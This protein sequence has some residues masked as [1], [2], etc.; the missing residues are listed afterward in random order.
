MGVLWSVTIS[1]GVFLA[2][3]LW[4]EISGFFLWPWKLLRTIIRWFVENYISFFKEP[5]KFLFEQRRSIFPWFNFFLLSIGLL[6]GVLWLGR[7]PEKIDL[8][9]KYL[10]EDSGFWTLAAAIAA[11]PFAWFIWFI[12]DRLK[13]IDQTQAEKDLV[14]EQYKTS[15]EQFYRLIDWATDKTNHPRAASSILRFNE[16]L[17]GGEMVPQGFQITRNDPEE[18]VIEKASHNPFQ[19]PIYN[20]L[21]VIVGERSRPKEDWDGFDAVDGDIPK[22]IKMGIETV[23]RTRGWLVGRDFSGWALW[24]MDLNGVNLEF[25]N[26][27]WTNLKKAKLWDANLKNTN[28][29]WTDLRGANLWWADLK[30]ANLRGAKL[31][32]ALIWEAHLQG[33]NLELSHLDNTTLFNSDLTKTNLSGANNLTWEQV[34]TTRN[35]QKAKLPD[36][37]KANQ[38]TLRMIEKAKEQMAENDLPFDSDKVRQEVLEYFNVPHLSK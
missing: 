31:Q 33:A 26:L 29:W 28:M 21:K 16:Y 3:L 7:H 32:G 20:T 1:S 6:Y 12:R 18:L 11:A 17:G 19:L 24:G 4:K 23:L 35:W 22:V 36:E 9:S 38:P 5:G 34:L 8:S 37:L 15:S 10:T 14:H 25:I 30:R 2:F 27:K 13:E